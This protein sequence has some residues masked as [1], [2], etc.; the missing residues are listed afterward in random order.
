MNKEIEEQLIRLIDKAISEAEHVIQ[1]AKSR[2]TDWLEEDA[3]TAKKNFEEL[4]KKVLRGELK[5]S[6]GNGLGITRGLSEMNAP[7]NLYK[8]GKALD[9]FYQKH[10]KRT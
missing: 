1:H 7:N 8:A 9:E 2:A 3:N 10:W 6:E 4:R 5:E